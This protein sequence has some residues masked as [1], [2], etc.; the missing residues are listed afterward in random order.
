MYGDQVLEVG[1]TKENS[2]ATNLH[3]KV[4]YIGKRYTLEIVLKF[5]ILE[6]CCIIIHINAMFIIAFSVSMPNL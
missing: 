1:A 2:V 6:S 3:A 5:Y 4:H